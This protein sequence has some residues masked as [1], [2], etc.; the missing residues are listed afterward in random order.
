MAASLSTK[1]I[2]DSNIFSKIR[3]VPLAWVASI[4]A[5]L[6]RVRGEA[7][8]WRIVYHR[9]GAAPVRLNL[10]SCSPGMVRVPLRGLH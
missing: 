5:V 10:E 7:R 2:L 1:N 6:V 4:T 9:Y 8:P 3:L